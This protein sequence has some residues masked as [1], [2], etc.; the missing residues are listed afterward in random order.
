MSGQNHFRKAILDPTA[1]VPQTLTNPN[2]QPAGKRFDVYRN[3]VAVSLTEALEAS[4][5]IVRRIVGDEFFK[6]MAGVYL[7]KHPPSSPLMMHYGAEMP[8]FLQRFEPVQ[9]LGYLPDVARLELARRRAYHAADA[10]PIGPNQMQ[11]ADL[12]SLRFTLAPAMQVIRSAWPLWGIW[13][14]NTD[15]SAPK[16][17]AEP[18]DILIT[19]P[20]YDPVVSLLPKGGAAFIGAL[21]RGESLGVAVLAPEQGFDPGP[22]LNLLLSGG[23]IT[24]LQQG[25]NP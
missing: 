5:P 24:G 20:E 13:L 14:A 7:R 18:E 10:A 3:N 6:A 8:R 11:G 4:F 2:G 1:P 21:S 17:Q 25:E 12:M 16:P 22:V 19:R 9:H 23:G 15:P